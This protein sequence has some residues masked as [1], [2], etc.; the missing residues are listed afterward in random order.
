MISMPILSNGFSTPPTQSVL[1]II[2][3]KDIFPCMSPFGPK[4]SGF[5]LLLCYT[6]PDTIRFFLDVLASSLSFRVCKLWIAAP[7]A[8]IFSFFPLVFLVLSP[9]AHGIT[10][11]NF[12]LRSMLI[13]VVVPSTTT[14]SL[15][16]GKFWIANTAFSHIFPGSFTKA[17]KTPT[18]QTAFYCFPRAKI[19]QCSRKS[20]LAFCAELVAFWKWNAIRHSS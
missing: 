16:F 10:T 1:T 18:S 17:D 8:H 13:I 3:T 15:F 20:L 14:E 5:V 19:I 11:T 6:T 7:D 2:L 12:C 4:F 9:A